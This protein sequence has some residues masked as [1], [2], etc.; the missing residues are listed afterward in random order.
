MIQTTGKL[1]LLT[2][3]MTVLSACA[4]APGGAPRA[5]QILKGAEAE[6]ATFAVYPVTR[7]TL[8]PLQA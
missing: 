1:L 5:D 2:V 8:P 6:D 3:G 4:D 7:D